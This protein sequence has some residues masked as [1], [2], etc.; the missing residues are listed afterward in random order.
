[1]FCLQQHSFVFTAVNTTNQI[2]FTST[3]LVLQQEDSVVDKVR[4]SAD[5]RE[6]I[7]MATYQKGKWEILYD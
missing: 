5:G 4:T 6:T 1:M 7:C 2:L 3:V